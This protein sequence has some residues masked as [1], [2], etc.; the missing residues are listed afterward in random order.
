MGE[1]PPGDVTELLKA[2]S[3]GDARALEELTPLVYT[4]IH[5]LAHSYLRRERPGQR[6]RP[7]SS[8]MRR[9]FSCCGSGE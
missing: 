5:R 1:Q 9:A 2:W 3:D 4:Q 7:P 8:S 6:C